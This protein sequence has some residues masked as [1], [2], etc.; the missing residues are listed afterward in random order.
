MLN[1]QAYEIETMAMGRKCRGR[2]LQA[3][4]SRI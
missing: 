4:I 3:V 2:K 1:I